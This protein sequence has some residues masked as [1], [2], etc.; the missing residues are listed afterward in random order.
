MCAVPTNQFV[1]SARFHAH[2]I[3]RITT[4]HSSPNAENEQSQI[5]QGNKLHVESA[6][7]IGD[8]EQ[9]YTHENLAVLPADF[10]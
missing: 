1:K 5:R 3:Q 9:C 2:R 4:D 10:T 6:S 8:M 7:M